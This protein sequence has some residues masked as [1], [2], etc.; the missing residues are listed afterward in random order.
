[1][2]A[3]LAYHAYSIWLF[4]RS[5][6]K[7]I[8]LPSSIFGIINAFS[9]SAYHLEPVVSVHFPLQLLKVYLTA[10]FWAWTNLLPFAIDNQL[11]PES[12]AEDTIN[13]PWR[14][15]PSKR[16]TPNQA[17]NLIAPLYTVAVINSYF[18]GGLPQCLILIVIGIWD[19]R[20]EGADASA[21]SRNCINGAGFMCYNSGAL[22]VALGNVP[23]PSSAFPWVL[24]IGLVVF[25]TVQ[26]QDFSDQEGDDLRGRKSLP[27]Q[28]G[29]GPARWLTALLMSFWSGFCPWLWGLSFTESA[30]SMFLGWLV[31]WRTVTKRSVPADNV[32]FRIWNLWMVTLYLLPLMQDLA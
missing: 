7:T 32:T 8:V 21:L 17:R 25:S 5:D 20:F 31:A 4:T 3:C 1:M 15:L 29:D 13:K 22:E 9:A 27:L 23:L 14:T 19:N 6:L 11:S 12:I 16:M 28:I 18:L 10:A 2:R 26:T 24:V 30:P